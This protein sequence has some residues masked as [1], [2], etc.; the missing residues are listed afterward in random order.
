[1]TAIVKIHYN[2]YDVGVFPEYGG[3]AY[4][5]L[6]SL[7]TK[8]RWDVLAAVQSPELSY[9]VDWETV[10]LFCQEGDDFDM[11]IFVEMF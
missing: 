4:V 5:P 2:T 8:H 1:M 3:V 7:P 9:A 10:L 6:Q 11:E